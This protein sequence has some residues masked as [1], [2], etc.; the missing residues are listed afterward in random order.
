MFGRGVF[1]RGMASGVVGDAGR[2]R[3]SE[4]ASGVVGDAVAGLGR[5]SASPLL[6]H[7]RGPGNMDDGDCDGR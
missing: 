1:G 5:G 2:R 3:I 7:S 6:L 4:G